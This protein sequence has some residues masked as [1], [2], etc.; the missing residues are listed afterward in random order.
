MNKTPDSYTNDEQEY[1]E[2]NLDVWAGEYVLGTLPQA[3]CIQLEQR[4]PQEPALQAAVNAWH[5]RL[6][7]LTQ[8]APIQEPSHQLWSRIERS[9]NQHLAQNRPAAV[10]PQKSIAS[11]AQSSGLRQIMMPWWNHLALWRGLAGLACACAVVLASLLVLELR[12]PVSEGKPAFMVVLVAPQNQSPGW[13]IQADAKDSIQLI[14]L[15]VASVPADRVLQFWT[16]AEG[17]SGPV[18]LGLIQPGPVGQ[19]LQIPLSQ[20]PPLKPN[21]LFELTLEPAS[22]SPTGKPTGPI[23]FIGRA[24]QVL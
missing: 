24:V 20:L 22:G 9:V 18:S 12:V 13:V 4:L 10:H 19:P 14:P 21:Q 2:H 5:D 8:L 17:W 23:Q 7:P 16:K 6:L 11:A 15:A 1:D 3:Q